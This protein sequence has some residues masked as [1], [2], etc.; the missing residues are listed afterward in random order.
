MSSRTPGASVTMNTFRYLQPH[1]SCLYVYLPKNEAHKEEMLQRS[2]TPR[3]KDWLPDRVCLWRHRETQTDHWDQAWAS[4]AGG[5][6]GD[7]GTRPPQWE[8]TRGRPQTTGSR[9]QVSRRNTCRQGC[10]AAQIWDGSGSGKLSR[11]RFRLRLR[12]KCL[13]GSGSGSGCGS[14]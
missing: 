3:R 5:G 1:K 12:A 11:L 2:D 7:G 13:N 14:G 4:K 8:I 6:G 9:S 10:R